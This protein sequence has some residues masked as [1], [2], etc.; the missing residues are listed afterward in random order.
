MTGGWTLPGE[1]VFT[2]TGPLLAVRR[3]R[4]ATWNIGWSSAWSCWRIRSS[5][6]RADEL[7]ALERRDHLVDVVAAA[8][9]HRADD[10]LRGDEAV[11]REEVRHLVRAAHLL[12]RASR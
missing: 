7:P 6:L 5:A 8:L 12:A 3:A 2:G 9:L 10:H 4:A 11:R 1:N